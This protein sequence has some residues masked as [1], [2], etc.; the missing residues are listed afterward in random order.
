M[1]YRYKAV[2]ESGQVVEGIHDANTE[3]EVISM[4]RGSKYMPITIE[5]TTESGSSM[6]ICFKNV[7]KKDLAVFCRQFFTMLNAGVSIIKI[8]DILEKQTDKKLMKKAIMSIYESVQKGMTLSESMRMHEKIFPPILIN[9]VEAGEMSG[10]LDTIMERMAAH[11]E[12]E[13]K[14]ENKIKGAMVYPLVLAIVA[15][16]VVIFLLVAVMPTFIGMFESSG[17]EIPMPTKI[18]LAISHSLQN[19]WYMYIVI[20]AFII[21]GIAYYIKTD[22]G[23][24]VID[25]MK[26]KIPIF[27]DTNIKIATSRFTRTLSILLYSGIPLMQGIDIA[28]KV[29]G[30]RYVSLKLENAKEEIRKGTPLSRTIKDTKVFPPMVDSMIK[31]GEESGSLDDILN[32]SADFYDEELEAALQKMT[33][34]LQP[35]MVVVMALIVGFIVISI[36][37]PMFDMVNTIQM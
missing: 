14:I 7:T 18:L 17:M 24:L 21:Y 11:Y 9:M 4:L 19:Y 2:T 10:S 27:K 29:I 12:K 28:S 1:Q 25:T 8:L 26:L 30:N 16:S 31:I 36:A 37:L 20:Q 23:G 33:E 34:L 6:A 22:A 5:L 32:K 15:T 13:N 35:L 3:K